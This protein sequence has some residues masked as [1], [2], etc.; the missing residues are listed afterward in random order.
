MTEL[1]ARELLIMLY[2]T[3][4][5]AV[6]GRFLVSQ[7]CR[8]NQCGSEPQHTFTH[9]VAI[10]KAASA[11][12]QGVLDNSTSLKKSLLIC[13]SPKITG[14][15]KKNKN[16]I[17]LASS[18]PVPDESSLEA[19]RVLVDFVSSLKEGDEPLFLISGGSSSLVEMPVDGISLQ[20]LQQINHYLL[21]SGKDIHQMNAWRQQFSQIKGGGLCN[22]INSSHVT[23]LLL[24]DVKDDRPEFIGSGLLVDTYTLPDTDDYL[25]TLLEHKQSALRGQQ[26]VKSE[27]AIQVDTHIIGNIRLAMQAVHQAALSQGLDSFIHDEFIEGEAA[28]VAG[29][30][31][32]YLKDAEP[33]IH[34]WGGE[35]TVRLPEK[36]GIGGRNQTLALSFAQYLV[37]QPGLHLLAAGTDGVDGNSNCAGAVVSIFTAKKAREMGFDIKAEIEKANA[38]LVLMATD[39]L[40]KG[41]HSNTNVMDIFIAYKQHA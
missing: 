29:N 6:D 23:Q 7:W 34:I 4:L 20:Q 24:S 14:Q 28:R 33:G 8:K 41:A 3:A 35:T 26:P 25:S 30:L 38:G 13:P 36:P 21:S 2:E 31:Y 27:K 12:L 11:M 1:T 17:C 15:L 9:C 39:D 10:G 5:D 37:E 32:E 18:H 16:I 22:W 40:V 19:G